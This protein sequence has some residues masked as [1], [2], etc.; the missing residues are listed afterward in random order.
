MTPD[1]ARVLRAARERIATPERW[2]QGEYARDAYGEKMPENDFSGAYCW[3]SIGAIRGDSAFN[4]SPEIQDAEDLLARVIG[5][6]TAFKLPDWNDATDRTHAEVLAAFD[7]AI[8]LATAE[9]AP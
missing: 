1:V 2:T 6:R 5:E 4:V 8:I 7:A 9:I 3:C